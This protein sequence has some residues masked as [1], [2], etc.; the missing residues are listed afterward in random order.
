M[1][2]QPSARALTLVR[3]FEQLRLV[4]YLPT[5]N[6][7]PTIGW[8]HTG[9]EVHVGLVWDKAHADEVFNADAAIRAQQLTKLLYGI[10]TTQGQ[11]DA[12]FSLLYNIG[13]TALKNS[14]LLRLHKA[15]LYRRAADEFLKWDHQAGRVVSGL[16]RRR[17]AERALYLS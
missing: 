15:G 17:T 10:P 13:Y 7:K 14:T 9:P 6:D 11:F 16:L 12:L 4:G 5:P 1:I 2:S 3:S 8:G